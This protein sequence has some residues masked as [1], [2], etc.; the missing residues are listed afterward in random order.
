MVLKSLDDS[1]GTARFVCNT[2]DD[3][4]EAVFDGTRWTVYLSDGTVYEFDLIQSNYRNP[5]GTRTM[6]YNT[7]KDW[8][9]TPGFQSL[10]ADQVRNSALPKEE[11]TVWHGTRMYNL[12]LPLQAIYFDYEKFGGFNH[13][14]EINQLALQ[15]FLA[16]ELRGSPLLT[17]P[18]LTTYRDVY[19]SRV[20]AIDRSGRLE[21]IR[22]QYGSESLAGTTHLLDFR[23]ADVFR[24][25]SLYSYKSVFDQGANGAD[26][27]GWR[28]YLHWKSDEAY[29]VLGTGSAGM[30][31]TNP[32]LA[33]E[34]G[35]PQYLRTTP[36]PADDQIPFGHAYVESPRLG[37]ASGSYGERFIPGDLY[38]VRATV[39]N[40][41][42]SGAIHEGIGHLDI[43]IVTGSDGFAGNSGIGVNGQ[44]GYERFSL[45][46]G[47]RSRNETVFS[48]FQRP[49]KWISKVGPNGSITTSNFFSMPN[50]PTQ[51][52]GAYLQIGPGNSDHT[53]NLDPDNSL[54]VVEFFQGNTIP[55]AYGAYAH[56]RANQADPEGLLTEVPAGDNI[57]SNFGIGL[58]WSMVNRIAKHLRGG[59]LSGNDFPFTLQYR[60]WWETYFQLF[61]NGGGR[62]ANQPTVFDDN[63]GLTRLELRRYSKNPYL[64]QSVKTYRYEGETGGH[65]DQGA[66][67][68]S[69]VEMDYEVQKDRLIENL[70]Y[71][72]GDPSSTPTSSEISF[73]YVV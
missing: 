43:N 54:D 62:W 21:E 3:P 50:Y 20:Q 17:F 40:D 22:L 34:G 24:L 29:G 10:E 11:A 58:A 25:D 72:I 32:Y 6:D 26:L 38:E 7:V 69:H 27:E 56:Y 41:Y 18:D 48:T 59:H 2:F 37:G 35:L 9:T 19:L 61:Q 5:T 23:D 46:G 1:S 52:Q 64:L 66:V 60:F 47:N 36:L 39:Y 63:T 28:R 30:L 71:Q 31:A 14:A 15:P 4:V 73:C 57:P 16:L 12:N 42:G 8:E 13:F 55:T 49:L 68:I 44:P 33:T 51:Y 45:T 53:Y 70:R 67:L 65:P